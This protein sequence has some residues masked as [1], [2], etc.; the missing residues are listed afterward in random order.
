M[1]EL[2]NSMKKSSF[3]V[4]DTMSIAVEVVLL[5]L[6]GIS[7]GDGGCGGGNV[8]CVIVLSLIGELCSSSDDVEI[9][10][11]V[12]LKLSPSPRVRKIEAALLST[13]AISSSINF[14]AQFGSTQ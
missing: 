13:S 6:I 12:P 5:L 11:V 10:G 4:S 14:G 1:A 9:S 2:L 8:C 3:V 7:D